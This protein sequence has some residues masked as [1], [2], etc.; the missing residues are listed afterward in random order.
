MS[1]CI[2][3]VFFFL[4]LCYCITAIFVSA[5]YLIETIFKEG[6]DQCGQYATTCVKGTRPSMC[7]H[8]GIHGSLEGYLCGGQNWLPLVG[9][10]GDWGQGG[11]LP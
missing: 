6:L 1:Y 5:Q 4:F 2:V 9:E 10:L 11:K 7:T 8:T 3:E